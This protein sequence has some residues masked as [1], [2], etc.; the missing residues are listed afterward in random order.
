MKIALRGSNG[1]RV[2]RGTHLEGPLR[3]RMKGSW[4]LRNYVAATASSRCRREGD[5]PLRHR[6]G[7]A[8]P[9]RSSREDL[10]KPAWRSVFAK[11]S[12]RLREAL[13]VPSWSIHAM[14][15]PWRLR[16]GFATSSRALHE[17]VAGAEG[18]E[19]PPRGLRE[20][21]ASFAKPSA[22]PTEASRRLREG[23]TGVHLETIRQIMTSPLTNTG[24]CSWVEIH[25]YKK[26]H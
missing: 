20:G 25:P 23:A 14:G 2:F 11:A 12:R 22:T 6:G 26:K 17:D 16:E 10:L 19:K 15:S 4:S 13:T 8:K 9:L 3:L 7:S 24:Y 5:S 1:F 21:F 18:F